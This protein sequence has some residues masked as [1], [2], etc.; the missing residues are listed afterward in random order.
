MLIVILGEGAKGPSV[1][2]IMKWGGELT[3]AG[4]IQAEEMGKAFRAIYPGGQGQFN[5]RNVTLTFLI[6]V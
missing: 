3:P 6:S 2:V 4:K 1:V 5:N